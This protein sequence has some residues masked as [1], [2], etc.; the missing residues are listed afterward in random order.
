M[1]RTAG[2]AGCVSVVPVSDSAS[3][4]DPPPPEPLSSVVEPV[5]ESSVLVDPVDVL[6]SVVVAVVCGADDDDGLP[7]SS[8][9]WRTTNTI[10]ST[11]SAPR[12]MPARWTPDSPRPESSPPGGVLSGEVM[13]REG[14]G[15][16]LEPAPLG[17]AGDG[18]R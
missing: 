18:R 15:A 3:S 2:A 5:V 9:P 14:Y 6:C 10:S 11:P 4:S 1:V 13:S 17:T 7:L 16:G 8:P 12:T